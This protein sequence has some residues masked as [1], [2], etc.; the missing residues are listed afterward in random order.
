[1]KD[2]IQCSINYKQNIETVTRH[3][4]LEIKYYI[5]YTYHF[6]AQT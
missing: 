2:G 3:Q 1:M 6:Q 4:F 5:Y